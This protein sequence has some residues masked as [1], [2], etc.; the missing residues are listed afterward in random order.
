MV[1]SIS[2]Q[3]GFVNKKSCFTNLQDVYNDW[4]LAVDQGYGVD[5]IYPKA[6]GINGTLLLWFENYRSGRI[7]QVVLNGCSS[8]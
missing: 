4:T 8:N 2:C 7:K 3:H 5:I 6:Y 1:L